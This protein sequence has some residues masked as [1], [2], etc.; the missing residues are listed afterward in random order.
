MTDRENDPSLLSDTPLPTQNNTATDMGA[1]ES[2]GPTPPVDA[3]APTPDVADREEVESFP[4]RADGRPR[5]RIVVRPWPERL[6]DATDEATQ[7]GT[8]AA[9]RA[10]LQ[11]PSIEDR[12]ATSS[13]PLEFAD[14]DPVDLLVELALPR[15]TFS[16]W[17]IVDPL[18]RSELFTSAI[19]KNPAGVDAASAR[20]RAVGYTA[21]RFTDALKALASVRDESAVANGKPEP[22][23]PPAPN[24]TTKLGAA[25][26]PNAERP[27]LS[28]RLRLNAVDSY[29]R[30][31]IAG[32]IDLYDIYRRSHLADGEEE[33]PDRRIEID[34]YRPIH[35]KIRA[36]LDAFDRMASSQN[37][38][39]AAAA[40]SGQLGPSFIT[41]ET[42]IALPVRGATLLA[43]AISAGLKQAGLEALIDPVLQQLSIKAHVQQE[44][45]PHRTLE[46]AGLRFAT[47][48]ALRVPTDYAEFN[49]GLHHAK[50]ELSFA[51]S[52]TVQKLGP[53][54]GWR[55]GINTHT[56]FAKSAR[57]KDVPG[58]RT[59]GVEES[60]K[61]GGGARYGEAGSKRPDAVWRFYGR[62]AAVFDV[63]PATDPMTP[64]RIRQFR[65]H[66]RSDI[67][68]FELQYPEVKVIQRW[69]P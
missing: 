52:E 16:D 26:R 55:H 35:D 33:T 8:G 53:G 11:A 58:I 37:F 1:N 21:S 60:F 43:R 27:S 15:R 31:T 3:P 48:A 36:D 17:L 12:E 4:P 13:H 66:I 62:P 22:I 69:P 6:P 49:R 64:K 7:G 25:P 40:L 46:R 18:R 28:E 50:K 68:I 65:D 67:K 39:E 42:Y 14:I 19:A 10:P 51:L 59:D 54:A 41:P 29:Y 38:G 44:Y 30:G 47:G 32:T 34:L 57:Q 24:E 5:T 20:A 63:K 61:F 2:R 23:T 9:E 56:G 45:D